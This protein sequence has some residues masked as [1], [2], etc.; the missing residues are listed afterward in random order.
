MAYTHTQLV[1]VRRTQGR[2]DYKAEN[3]VVQKGTNEQLRERWQLRPARE[4]RCRRRVRG[5][6]RWVERRDVRP[7]SGR[8]QPIMRV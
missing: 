3:M 8:W 1:L 7:R 4:P 5:E 6:C 2:E